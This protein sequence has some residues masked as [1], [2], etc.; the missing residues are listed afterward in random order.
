MSLYCD[1]WWWPSHKIILNSNGIAS[2]NEENLLGIL[3]DSKLNFHSHSTILC[4]KAGQKLSGLA[5]INQYL[6]PVQKFLLLNSAVKFQFSYCPLIWT[7]TSR[8]LNNALNSIHE[9]ALRLIYNDCKLPF[10]RILEDD[11][12]KSIHQ[13]I[14]SH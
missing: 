2:S 12:Q 1:R 11:K 7:F 14:L 3:L 10:H 13:K 8:Y 4:K 5:K 9:R 6:T